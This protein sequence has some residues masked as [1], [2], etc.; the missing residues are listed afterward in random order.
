MQHE[1]AHT[2]ETLLVTELVK[3]LVEKL[4]KELVQNVPNSWSIFR[5][6]KLRN[7]SVP[8]NAGARVG[9]GPGPPAAPAASDST[10]ADEDVK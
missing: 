1:P 7:R 2:R 9:P 8:P 6:S 3:E 10:K 5:V 4:V